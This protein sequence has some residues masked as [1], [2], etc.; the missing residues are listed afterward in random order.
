[1]K[2][3]RTVVSQGTPVV[4]PAFI[5]LSHDDIAVRAYALYRQRGGALGCDRDDWYRA[6]WELKA[7]GE[8]AERRRRVIPGR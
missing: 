8:E 6:E 1:M 5:V 2:P 3:R 7:E 4:L